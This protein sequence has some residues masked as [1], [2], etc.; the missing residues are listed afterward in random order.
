MNNQD[1][2]QKAIENNE[3]YAIGEFVFTDWQQAFDTYLQ[4]AKHGDTKAQFNLGYMYARGD[5]M[6]RDFGKAYEWYQKAADNNDPRAHYNLSKM[7]EM[8]EFVLP[9]NIK[10]QEHLTLANELG[11]DR[12]RKRTVLAN[13]KEALKLGDRE[14]A[15][16][17]FSSI[18][19]NSKE[20]EMGIIA[21]NTVFKS[22]YDTQ[23]VYSY[24]S[25]GTG[26][27]KKFWKWGDSVKT[28][29]DLTMTNHSTQSWHVLVKALIRA[30]DGFV[31]IS[32]IGGVLKAG[33]TQSNT[34]DPEEFGDSKICGV[35]VYS[36]RDGSLDKPVYSFHFPDVTIQPD[37]A[38]TQGLPNKILMAQ[39]EMNR[40]NK[41]A[42]PGACF[43]L[44]ACYGSYDAPT[45]LAFRQFR[46]NHLAQYKLGRQFICWY[47]AHGPRWANSIENKPLIK[48][49]FRAAFNLLAKALP[50]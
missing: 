17:L 27:K 33:E 19:S 1:D 8:G 39:D 31:H 41:T 11:D 18:S 10:A 32:T 38:E 50:K 49:I 24:H 28:E 21:C 48:S 44:T 46:D 16:A 42:K 4:L 23:I 7:Y 35:A 34:I 13:A 12:A 36:D 30:R 43:V 3:L 47:Y 9:N 45:V 29:V 15:R 2:I 37:E 5:I 22:I 25:S 20:A 26:Q 6:E 40:N 14:K